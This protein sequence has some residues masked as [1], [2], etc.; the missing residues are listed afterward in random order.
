MR[1]ATIAFC[2]LV[3]F[4]AVVPSA[5][6]GQ[7]VVGTT[8][9]GSGTIASG[10]YACGPVRGTNVS[11]FTCP[12]Y[13][14]G[15][16]GAPDTPVVVLV[17]TPY[18]QP[19]GQWAFSNWVG[20]PIVSG[21]QCVLTYTGTLSTS[22]SVGA[23]FVDLVAPT[24]S[25]PVAGYS[26]TAERTVDLAWTASEP[27]TFACSLD[28]AALTPCSSPLT[29]SLPE[30]AHS[31]RVQA[32]D[33]SGNVGAVGPPLAFRI[34]DTALLSGPADLS[35]DPMST[36]SFSTVAGNGFDCSVD[37]GAFVDC[38][39]GGASGIGF[40]TLAH[41][42][43]GS[44]T[45]SVRAKNG[46]DVDHVP[47][48]RTWTVDTTPPSTT[49][50]AG[51]LAGTVQTATS[52][53]FEFTASEP[54]TTECSLDSAPFAACASPE[55]VSR[56]GT[57]THTFR[58]RAIDRAGNIGAPAA[59]SWSVGSVDT[60]TGA[61]V[62]PITKHVK[63]IL[64]FAGTAAKASTWFTKLQVKDVP[65][66]STVQVTCNG[67]GCPSGLKGKGY[68]KKKASGTVTLARFIAKPIKVKA[69]LTFLISKPG[70][71]SAVKILQLRPAK[72]P[73]LTTRCRMP[74]AKVSVAC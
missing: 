12:V 13:A 45:F 64:A 32:T 19:A 16:L 7:I 21:N 46:A 26:A 52:S 39:T 24:V 73:L 72:S 5:R 48:I 30:G 61:A 36:F 2:C 69:T 63:V 50:A 40:T 51:P 17:A 11:S 33:A 3:A 58:V 23:V 59:R 18:D 62:K 20:C 6:A 60:L 74:G 38:G 54:G 68:T 49:L 57:G 56:L 55:T 31:L 34:V 42:S 67:S 4:A 1:L 43:D 53:T 22:Y 44:H 47:A 28:S 37:G 71:I 8:V 35:N 66:G 41:L 9:Q 29:V 65:A 70:A 27:A 10:S 15:T 25:A 14:S